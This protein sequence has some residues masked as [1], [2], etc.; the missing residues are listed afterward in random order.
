MGRF[1][2]AG[3]RVGAR[4]LAAL[5]STLILAGLSSAAGVLA[6]K[7][8]TADQLLQASGSIFC[9]GAVRGSG[10]H[11][12]QPLKDYSII[13]TAAHVLFDHRTQ[14]RFKT[15]W[16]RGN[17]ARFAAM[18]FAQI[19]QMMVSSS[20]RP[21]IQQSE[22][23][24]VFIALKR[25]LYAPAL[26]LK[27]ELKP[28]PSV[29]EAP[30]MATPLAQIGYHAASDTMRIARGCKS[31]ATP[32][33]YNK[34]LLLHDCATGPGASGGP[35]I[36]DRDQRLV[37]V[38][39]GTLLIEHLDR[40]RDRDRKHGGLEHKEEAG[41]EGLR[42]NSRRN[43]ELMAQQPIRLEIRQGRA[44]DDQVLRQLDE[45]IHR[46]VQPFP[47]TCPSRDC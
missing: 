9:D 26:Q 42:Q 40:D 28:V 32:Y 2:I 14:R 11:I 20:D 36:N 15:C 10:A 47:N 1:A 24:L 4:P 44:I 35:L 17:N 38:H 37:A 29:I 33:F 23:D 16:Y 19:S 3:G 12:Q 25:R 45:F 5:Y 8:L 30:F 6:S 46:L 7:P 34:K 31:L 43:N 18:P 13:V 27:A 21:A 22:N 39:G 41:Q